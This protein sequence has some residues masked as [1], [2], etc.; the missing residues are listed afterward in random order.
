[1]AMR[2]EIEESH[3]AKMATI[4]A[5]AFANY[6]LAAAGEPPTSLHHR[7]A[8]H[9]RTARHR[10]HRRANAQYRQSRRDHAENIALSGLCG[11]FRYERASRHPLRDR[12]QPASRNCILSLKYDAANTKPLPNFAPYAAYLGGRKRSPTEAT[13]IQ[14]TA[15]LLDDLA[16]TFRVFFDDLARL[17]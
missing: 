11:L 13:S 8:H 15:E 17:L 1:M 4:S 12:A 2:E 3:H 6:L 5:A 14:M 10:H 9:R 7:R 16:Q